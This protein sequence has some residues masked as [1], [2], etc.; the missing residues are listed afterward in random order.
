V[1][2]EIGYGSTGRDPFERYS[3]VLLLRLF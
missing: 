2:G 1:V 3:I